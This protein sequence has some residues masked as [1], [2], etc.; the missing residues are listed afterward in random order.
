MEQQRAKLRKYCCNVTMVRTQ[1]T[2]VL[3]ADVLGNAGGRS[4]TPERSQV[5]NGD[6]YDEGV[7]ANC[8]EVVSGHFH[9]IVLVGLRRFGFW[10]SCW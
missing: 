1:L 3:V 9:C 5:G 2:Q 6:N 10:C 8:V 4:D 7:N